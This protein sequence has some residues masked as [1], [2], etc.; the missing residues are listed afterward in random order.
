MFSGLTKFFVKNADQLAKAANQQPADQEPKIDER[1]PMLDDQIIDLVDAFDKKHGAKASTRTR[2]RFF[3]QLVIKVL[4]NG[5][6]RENLYSTK[7]YLIALIYADNRLEAILNNEVYISYKKNEVLAD[8]INAISRF[9]LAH[10]A[11]FKEFVVKMQSRLKPIELCMIVLAITEQI[12]DKARKHDTLDHDEKKLITECLQLISSKYPGEISSIAFSSAIELRLYLEARELEL[13]LTDDKTQ[14]AKIF[15]ALLRYITFS[16]PTAAV[17]KG[18]NTEELCMLLHTQLMP[19]P[20]EQLCT[21]NQLVG[22]ESRE[23]IDRPLRSHL[24][25]L[26]ISPNIVLICCVP[27]RSSYY[28]DA[29][30]VCNSIEDVENMDICYSQKEDGINLNWYL[31]PKVDNMIKQEPPAQALVFSVPNVVATRNHTRP[32]SNNTKV[33]AAAS[34]ALGVLSTAMYYRNTCS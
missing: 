24:Q 25:P 11:L 23:I 27:S 28:P 33:V 21:V 26:S 12:R 14:K 31:V 5:Q 30:Y 32:Q 29:C 16:P 9:S 2:E 20:V 6:E 22:Y 4:R 10:Q 15:Y 34:F 19:P 1:E 13:A 3:D 8:L 7:V 17:S 18:L